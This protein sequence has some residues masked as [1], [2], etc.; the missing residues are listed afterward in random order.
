MLFVF[1]IFYSITDNR[2]ASDDRMWTG[3]FLWLARIVLKSVDFPVAGI[4][5]G[6]NTNTRLFLCSLL[7]SFFYSSALV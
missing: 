6:T 3:M 7:A 1:F 2:I 4:V 5:I